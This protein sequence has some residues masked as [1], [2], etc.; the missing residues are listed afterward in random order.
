MA[1]QFD[2][3]EHSGLRATE[4]RLNGTIA[5]IA[6]PALELAFGRNAL[7]PGAETDA[8]H[9]ASDND[10]DNYVHP[11]SFSLREPAPRGL[12]GS[13]RRNDVMYAGGNF[14]AAAAAR[15]SSI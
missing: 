9:A 14:H 12:I 1:A 8:L 2:H 4:H 15:T 13:Q 6:D 3:G 5:A 11:N 7:G 10:P